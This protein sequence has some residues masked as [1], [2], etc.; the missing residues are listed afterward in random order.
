MTEL[1][2]QTYITCDIFLL[3]QD[4]IVYIQPKP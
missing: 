1:K 3:P 2:K 4:M